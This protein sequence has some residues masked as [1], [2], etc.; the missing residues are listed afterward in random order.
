MKEFFGKYWEIILEKSITEVE[1]TYRTLALVG[2]GWL[3]AIF[4]F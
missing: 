3:V 4:L 1:V 2:F